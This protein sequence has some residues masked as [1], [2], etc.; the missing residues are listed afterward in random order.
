MISSRVE[1]IVESALVGRTK[2][3]R[4]EEP[5]KK[6]CV[7]TLLPFLREKRRTVGDDAAFPTTEQAVISI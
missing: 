6:Q 2:K 7:E 5:S 1:G 3:E 4:L